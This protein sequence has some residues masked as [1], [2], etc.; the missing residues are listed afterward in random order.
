MYPDL[1]DLGFLHL[2]TYG[3]CMAVGFILCWTLIERLS[4]RKDLSNFIL[5]LMLSGV[6]GSRI[7][8]V[9]EHWRSE[10]AARA[11]ARRSARRPGGAHVLRGANPR[12]RRV[13]RVVQVEEGE[14]ARA[15]GPLLHGDSARTRLRTH[16]V[17]LLRML[18]RT[19]LGRVVRGR[20]PPVLAELVR[21]RTADGACPSD[22][23]LRGR[24]AARPLR[25]ADGAVPPLQARHMRRVP[26]GPAHAP[27][28]WWATA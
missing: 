6:V 12:R 5:A 18:L 1:I 9:V 4:K 16:R 13:L 26:G 17:L 8:Y 25:G 11:S 23:A 20:V 24:G 22:A 21:A 3:A 2:K 10:F 19:R 15:R 7:A 27:R 14:P 28:T